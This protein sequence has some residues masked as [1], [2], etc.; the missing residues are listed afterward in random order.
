MT[1]LTR[2]LEIAMRKP[3]YLLFLVGFVVFSPAI[4]G[5][6][7][8][9]PQ[10]SEI[11]RNWKHAKLITLDLTDVP[12]KKALQEIELQSG[13]KMETFAAGD[14][15]TTLKLKDASLLKAIAEASISAKV[16]FRRGTKLPS[17][18]FSRLAKTPVF[19]R[20]QIIGPFNI[21]FY[22]SPDRWGTQEN[23]V[24]IIMLQSSS[25]STDGDPTLRNTQC[26]A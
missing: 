26:D 9:Q 22:W 18:E 17:I 10:S 21:G 8:A 19:D 3:F 12:L 7:A 1:K 13:V 16:P 24:P 23:L 15:K 14:E 5:P 2:A 4:A 25:L 11:L 6:L 20:Y